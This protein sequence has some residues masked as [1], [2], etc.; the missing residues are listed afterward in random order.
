VEIINKIT[1][2]LKLLWGDLWKFIKYLMI[3]FF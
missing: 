3:Q 1:G 2:H